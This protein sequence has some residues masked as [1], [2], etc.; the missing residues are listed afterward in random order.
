MR[1]GAK[2]LLGLLLPTAT[3]PLFYDVIERHKLPPPEGCV[4]WASLPEWDRYWAE[5]RPPA[6]IGAS[7]VQHGRG[8]PLE[9]C[10][11]SRQFADCV[12][13]ETGWDQPAFGLSYCV[14]RTTRNM[15]FCSSAPR[16]PEQVNVQ[17]ASP[18]AVVISF[19]TFEP[20]APQ[21][22]P[23]ALVRR[24]GV[25]GQS[26]LHGVTH[27]HVTTGGRVYYMHFVR[28]AGLAPR[29]RY[30]YRVRSGGA[31]GQLSDSFSFRSP[32]SEG[33]T[34]VDL[35]GKPPRYR[36]H[37]GCILLKMAAILSLTGLA[38]DG[39]VPGHAHPLR[40]S[41]GWC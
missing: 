32:Y 16:V 33:E 23:V 41:A 8:N 31:G 25:A 35:F 15:T 9:P 37:L 5:G 21:R 24:Q 39:R 22:P 14:S 20:T 17:I 2:L 19:V 13:N 7:C 30:S 38:D 6:D 40:D 11:H 4:P 27:R 3:H 12:R 29:T 10:A 34:R 26:E 1:V 28:L 36:C 18:T